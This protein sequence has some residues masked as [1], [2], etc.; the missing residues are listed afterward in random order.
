VIIE[1]GG[2]AVRIGEKGE[3]YAALYLKDIEGDFIVTAKLLNQTRTGAY[4]GAGVMVRNDIAGAGSSAG[5]VTLHIEPKYGAQQPFRADLDGDGVMDC[6]SYGLGG[7]PMLFE[8]KKN[9][10]TFIAQ[11]SLDEKK[12]YEATPQPFYEVESANTKQDIGIFANAFSVNNELSRVE[13]EYIT[14]Q[15]LNL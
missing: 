15:K 12:W 6:M 8:L 5:Y 10:K 4:A 3:E 1:A 14:I 9:G 13:F 2:G 11:T 7:R